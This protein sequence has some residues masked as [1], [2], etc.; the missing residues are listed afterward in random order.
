MPAMVP[1][2]AAEDPDSGSMAEAQYF[3]GKLRFSTDFVKNGFI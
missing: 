2:S 1:I 3:V